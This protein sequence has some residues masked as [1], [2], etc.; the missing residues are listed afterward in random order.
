MAIQLPAGHVKLNL[1]SIAHIIFL[2]KLCPFLTLRVVWYQHLPGKSNQKPW[3]SLWHLLL[4]SFF[5]P[6]WPVGLFLSI[7]TGSPWLVSCHPL[8]TS[9]LVSS[10]LSW[11]PSL[12]IT[13]LIKW[14]SKSSN[15]AFLFLVG[16]PCMVPHC[17]QFNVQSWELE[18]FLICPCCFFR[19]SCWS[20]APS[21]ILE[22]PT[23]SGS[24]TAQELSY[25]ND[26]Y[27]CFTSLPLLLR[28]CLNSTALSGH[29]SR[30]TWSW[31]LF[32]PHS[33]TSLVSWACHCPSI[34]Q[35]AWSLLSGLS[36]LCASWHQAL[37]FVHLCKMVF[38]IK[39]ET[40]PKPDVL[41]T[42]QTCIER[43]SADEISYWPTPWL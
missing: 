2:L 3:S 25:F 27:S 23:K 21:Q 19:L 4:H 30:V 38:S 1:F 43:T 33:K 17:F 6:N 7:L 16:N 14:T 10:L 41:S 26:F 15:A 35:P 8:L 31:D 5:M 29:S 9:L 18:S 42:G 11:F 28:L 12:C 24:Q 32:W 34:D 13:L 37:C 39:H 36:W 22:I 20:S 40:N